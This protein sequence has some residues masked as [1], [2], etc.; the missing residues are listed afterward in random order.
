MVEA[1]L[2]FPDLEATLTVSRIEVVSNVDLA[3]IKR[4]LRWLFD[5][6]QKQQAAKQPSDTAAIQQQVQDALAACKEQKT[7]IESLQNRQV[8]IQLTACRRG[9]R[10]RA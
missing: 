2:Q 9:A 8:T 1:Q 7:A 6:L 10:F 4:A 5:E 3:T